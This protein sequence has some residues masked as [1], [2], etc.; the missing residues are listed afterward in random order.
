MLDA[1]DDSANV[2]VVMRELEIT[3]LVMEKM[4]FEVGARSVEQSEVAEG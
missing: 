4:R 1:G 3:K 2:G